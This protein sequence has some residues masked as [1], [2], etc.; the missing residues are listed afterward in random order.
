M[1]QTCV[2]LSQGH[3]ILSTWPRLFS[4]VTSLCMKYKSMISTFD[5][6]L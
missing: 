5:H 1:D 3:E 6:L 4:N 2:S